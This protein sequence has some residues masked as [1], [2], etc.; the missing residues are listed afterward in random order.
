MKTNS[1]TLQ[2][3]TARTPRRAG[4]RPRGHG[5][6]ATELSREVVVQCAVTL[7]RKESI[8]ELTMVRVARELDVAPGLIHY[9]IGNRDDLLSAVINTAFKQRMEALPALKNNWRTDLEGVARSI[10]KT[11]E[12]WPGLATYLGTHNR[13]RLFQRV[14]FDEVDYGLA[15][16]DHLGSILKAAGF[17]KRQAALA[18]H[19]F[20]LFVMSIAVERDNRQA[21]GEHEDYIVNYVS[22]FDRDSIPGA[23]YLVE[24][25]AKI[26]SRKAFDTG[27]ALLLDGLADW[28]SPI[29]KSEGGT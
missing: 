21:P 9:Y 14:T 10:V 22:G 20:M 12:Q 5:A 17:S 3:D 27:L 1:K 26:D 4:R 24:P 6:E 23:N 16:F 13:S 11:L 19:L 7:V 25:F 29:R 18:Y 28:L 8:A 2:K 15:F